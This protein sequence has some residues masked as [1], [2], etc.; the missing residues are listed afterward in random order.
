MSDEEIEVKILRPQEIPL[1]VAAGV[2][3]VGIT[4]IDWVT[5]TGA[6]VVKLLDLEYGEVRVTSA[7]PK[8]SGYDSVDGFLGAKWEKGE[9]VRASTEYLNL[10]SRYMKSLPS[11][12]S[13]FGDSDPLLVT[14]WWTRGQNRRAAVYL[15]FGATEAK[16]P[17]DADFILDVS[18]TGSSLEQNNLKAMD[19]VLTS[20][21]HLI[22]SRAAM[23]DRWKKEK[24]YDLVAMLKGVV[25]ARKRV[26]I[27]VN[28]REEKLGEL[29]AVLP[30]L[31]EPTVSALSKK[32]WLAVNTVVTKGELHR[33]VP[34]IRKIA[35]GLV[36]HEPRQ[37]LSIDEIRGGEE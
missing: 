20:T 15:S 23:K 33:I 28:V 6:D 17:D 22:A 34:S 16:P 13:A 7:I 5:E 27:Y 1:Y 18:E 36:V 24:V 4:G 11:Y 14:P 8:G 19:T 30:A 31:K 21:A 25:S 10:T 37:V 2:H 9:T 26:H 12:R 3:D 35:Q 29:L 32:G